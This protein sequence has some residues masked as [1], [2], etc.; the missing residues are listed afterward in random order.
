MIESLVV[1]YHDRVTSLHV[2]SM[3]SWFS[4]RCNFF[5][6]IFLL[7]KHVQFKFSRTN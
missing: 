5:P 1:L 2:V 7:L 4:V 6:F 3:W